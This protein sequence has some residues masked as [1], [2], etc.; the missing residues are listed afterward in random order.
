MSFEKEE[1]T[2]NVVGFHMHFLAHQVGKLLLGEPG[3]QKAGKI[4]S[5]AQPVQ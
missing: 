3:A 1:S 4:T 5:P 2:S